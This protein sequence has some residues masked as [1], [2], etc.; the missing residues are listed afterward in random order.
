MEGKQSGPPGIDFTQDQLDNKDS[1]VI[2]VDGDERSSGDGEDERREGNS[3]PN[4][5]PI[6]IGDSLSLSSESS[7]NESI[8]SRVPRVD[9][10]EHIVS[11]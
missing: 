10:P 4:T 3:L 8:K 9:C 7:E 11:T 2:N 5:Q 1:L 6:G